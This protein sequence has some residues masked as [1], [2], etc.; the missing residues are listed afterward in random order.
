MLNIPEEIH[1]GH[2]ALGGCDRHRGLH[3]QPLHRRASP[4]R[5]RPAAAVSDRRPR[6]AR[7]QSR[8]GRQTS[9]QYDR[10]SATSRRRASRPGHLR[11][12]HHG[13]DRRRNGRRWSKRRR[14]SRTRRLMR[15]ADAELPRLRTAEAAGRDRADASR[16]RRRASR[17]RR[18]K[19]KRSGSC[20]RRRSSP[21]H[22]PRRRSRLRLIR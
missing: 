17:P 3:R 2:L 20:C 13:E 12:G 7:N 8:A 9:R 14:K 10:P 6:K 18:A 15:K 11:E 4:A 22:Q 21:R 5:M 16:A 19:R 1:G